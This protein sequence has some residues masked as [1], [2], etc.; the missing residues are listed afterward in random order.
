MLLPVFAIS[1]ATMLASAQDTSARPVPVNATARATAVRARETPAIDGRSDDAVWR[2]A[3][4]FS[5]FRQFEPRV[6]VPPSFKTEFQ[7]AY[8]EKHLYV[9]ARMFD[10]HPDSIM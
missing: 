8:D 5:E 4:K 7:V 3:P 6:D 2:D 1:A 10:P 9:F